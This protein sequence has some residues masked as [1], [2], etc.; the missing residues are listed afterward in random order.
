MNMPKQGQAIQLKQTQTL[1]VTPQ[2]TQ[3]LHILQC[4]QQ[5]L[6]ME[7][8]Q[9]LDK[10]IMLEQSDGLDLDYQPDYEVD[11][12]NGDDLFDSMPD[13][14][15]DAPD[16]D[17]AW[18]DIYDDDYLESFNN[19]PKKMEDIEG[20]QDDWVSD[21]LSFDA[22]LERAIYL[23]P[24]SQEEQKLAR[25]ILA[26]LDS[27]YFLIDSVEQL[28]RKLRTEMSVL[29]HVLDVLRHL[30]PAGVACE[31]VR[32]CLLA[33]LRSSENN[34]NTAVDAHEILSDYF[35]YIDKKP[36]FI[37]RRLGISESEYNEAMQLI[38]SL[39]PYPDMAS[40][41]NAQLI[42]PEVFVRQRMG[43]FYASPNQ[44]ARFDLAV[45]ESYATL[46]KH[47]KG[48]E[49]HFMKAQLQEAKFFL[50][51]LEQRHKTVVRVA[52]AI[53]MQ[54]QEYFIEGEK[55]M[56]PLVMRE[57]AEQ[58]ELSESTISRAVNGKYLSFNQHLIELRFFFT[59]GLSVEVDK[60]DSD[61]PFIEDVAT[62]AMA[63]KAHIKEIIAT[64][65]PRK[66]F[67]DSKIEAQLKEKGIEIS[68]RTIS[69]Y[70]E[71]MGVP[72]AS[73]RKRLK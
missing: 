58:L 30:D 5:Q 4:N 17:M 41:S 27:D 40:T 49:K 29:R 66:P 37:C 3:R 61:D 64:E 72:N 54:Q 14:F 57:I 48:D 6:G 8:Q 10:N 39:S 26:H 12:A 68:R 38:R 69:K 55:A 18:E 2:M 11:L 28:A 62:S 53:V 25:N 71:A 9:M 32:E 34:S 7:I 1:T 16:A 15:G 56:R 35:D 63:V 70:R 46:T 20:F 65:P 67:S 59:Q 52:N 33:Q 42:K 23:S 13:D 45:N 50:D 22:R 43:V 31:G 73:Q 47:C 19:Q 21:E 51:A 24:L 44:D 60:M 36:A